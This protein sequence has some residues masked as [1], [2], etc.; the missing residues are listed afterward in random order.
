MNRALLK[1]S[2]PSS[3]LLSFPLAGSR[4]PSRIFSPH[5]SI[6]PSLPCLSF[7]GFLLRK[8][9]TL[10]WTKRFSLSYS[11]EWRGATFVLSSDLLWG[12]QLEAQFLASLGRSTLV[13]SSGRGDALFLSARSSSR[14]VPGPRGIARPERRP[15]RA[16]GSLTRPLPHHTRPP[17]PVRRRERRG[18][19]G[20]Q[21]EAARGT[22]RE[23]A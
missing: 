10:M 21:E 14:V 18:Q 8:N 22:T 17:H 3:L 11:F 7:C 19:A 9:G 12:W 15:L 16:H 1:A 5:P 2:L 6:C 23:Q 13:F 20:A 4:P